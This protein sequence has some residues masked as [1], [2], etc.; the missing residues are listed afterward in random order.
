MLKRQRF[1]NRHYPL[2]K[3][4]GFSS[5]G[6]GGGSGGGGGGSYQTVAVAVDILE[7]FDHLE[8]IAPSLKVNEA[9]AIIRRALNLN[10]TQQIPEEFVAS[11]AA[12][13]I[14]L[15]ASQFRFNLRN[16]DLQDYLN[17]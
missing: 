5:G 7:L 15:A 2:C 14:R 16:S 13:I 6:G 10:D 11:N 12:R 4:G 3:R 17:Y 8:V 9:H 1:F